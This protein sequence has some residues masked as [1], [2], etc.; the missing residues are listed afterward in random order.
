MINKCTGYWLD[1]FV[2]TTATCKTILPKFIS[3][4]DNLTVTIIIYIYMDGLD[5]WHTMY[6]LN[7]RYIPSTQTDILPQ[8]K[9]FLGG[10]AV[11]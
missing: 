9:L 11:L 7:L 5:Q 2:R 8:R 3:K 1:N 6:K 4:E 10:Y